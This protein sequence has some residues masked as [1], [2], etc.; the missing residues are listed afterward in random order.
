MVRNYNM[1]WEFQAK[2]LGYFVFVVWCEFE[3]AINAYKMQLT[4]RILLC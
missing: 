1:H 2:D 3:F 4:P